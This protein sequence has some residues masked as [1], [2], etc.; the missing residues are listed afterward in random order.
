MPAEAHGL[1]VGRGQHGLD[2][3]VPDWV[4]RIV[5][6]GVRRHGVCEVGV[7]W[8]R[9]A[10]AGGRGKVH[11]DAAVAPVDLGPFAV[12]VDWGAR[13]ANVTFS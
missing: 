5:V 1:G 11:E 8:R 12:G 2:M 4:V 6:L 7:V 10:T 3:G 9:W 13:L